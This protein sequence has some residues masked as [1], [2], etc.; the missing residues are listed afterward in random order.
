[1]DEKKMQKRLNR[2]LSYLVITGVIL[3]IAGAFFILFLRNTVDQAADEQMKSETGEY[4]KRLKKQMSSDLQ[5]LDT[6]AGV[7]ENSSISEEEEFPQ[8]LADVRAQNDFLSMVYFTVSGEGIV[9]TDAEV[10]E[11]TLEESQGEM[12]EV[13]TAVLS[14]ESTISDLFWSKMVN[15]NAFAYGVPVKKDGVITGALCASDHVEIFTDILEGQQVMGGSGS[16]NLLSQ[17]GDFLLRFWEPL[18]TEEKATIFSSP[19]LDSDQFEEVREKMEAE[20]EIWFSFRYEGESYRSYLEPLGINGWYLLCVSSAE[21][22]NELLSLAVKVMGAVS[23]GILIIAALWLFYIQRVVRENMKELRSLAYYDTLTGA[24]NFYRFTQLAKERHRKDSECTIVALNVH[25]FKLINEIFGKEQ[26]DR[27]ICHISDTIHGCIRE[28][29]LFCRESA[30]FFYLFLRDTDRDRIRE[31]MKWIMENG[32]GYSDQEGEKYH[33]FLYCGAVISRKSETVYEVDQMLTHVMFAL[34]KARETHQNNVWFFDSKLHEKELMN[35]YVESHM[36]QALEDK[37]FR[38]FLQPQIDLATGKVC[39][40]EAL[41]RWIKKDGK[42]IYPDQ[43]IPLF[44]ENGFCKFLDMYMV[45]RVCSCIRGWI[46]RGY[47]PVPVSVNQSKTVIFEH[48]FT[49]KLYTIVISWGISPELITLEILEGM[50]LKNPNDLNR[51]ISMLKEKGFRIAMDDFGSGYSSLNTLGQIQIDELKLDRGFLRDVAADK[52]K[53][54][55]IIMEQITEMAKKLHIKTV[56]EGV[57][58]GENDRMI[59]EL[60]CDCGQGYYYGKPVSAEEFTEK[61]IIGGHELN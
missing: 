11:M 21:R 4:V 61:Y 22:S 9:V 34:D 57:E 26:A 1:M 25:Q 55:W 23:A 24:Y 31:R 14:G 44:E 54:S 28:D 58:T 20:E 60:G 47:E 56:V 13:V 45:D 17:N 12:R 43:F 41:V 7:M 46:N 15:E 2:I 10:R 42:I 51:K 52:N 59:R 40:A 53:K 6:I 3:L 48:N 18:K 32:A 30:D 16:I 50:A 36:Y 5:L 19:Y 39:G 37:E 29:E 33:T 27:L 35:N 8:I 38:L 49:R